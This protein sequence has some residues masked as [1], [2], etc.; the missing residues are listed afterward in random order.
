M[1]I[2][3]TCVGGARRAQVV[4]SS[5]ANGSFGIGSSGNVINRISFGNRSD[6][7][8]Y[9]YE[10]RLSSADVENLFRMIAGDDNL[11]SMLQNL[12]DYPEAD[13]DEH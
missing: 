3:R 2:T 1:K 12:R 5:S 8:N 4:L 11:M 6:D 10:V 13:V 7:G 9:E